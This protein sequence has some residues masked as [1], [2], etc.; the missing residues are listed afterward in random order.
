MS[1]SFGPDD[2]RKI[3][4][5]FGNLRGFVIHYVIQPVRL[6]GDGHARGC[7]RVGNMQEG[8]D[9]GGIANQWKGSLSNTLNHSSRSR[10][11][12]SRTVQLSIPEHHPSH[13]TE[14]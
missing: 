12:G 4:K 7:R 11:A 6:A 10:E 1:G 14:V 13:I 8:P 2:L 9:P 5:P 3:R